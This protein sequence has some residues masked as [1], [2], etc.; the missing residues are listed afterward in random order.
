MCRQIADTAEYPVGSH[1]CSGR[2]SSLSAGLRERLS[3]DV[4]A[5]QLAQRARGRIRR[6]GRAVLA[7]PYPELAPDIGECNPAAVL[8]KVDDI[9]LSRSSLTL[10]YV[11][12]S[13]RSRPTTI[14]SPVVGCRRRRLELVEP[15]SSAARLLPPY[16]AYPRLAAN[17]ARL[18]RLNR[19]SSSSTSGSLEEQL[20]HQG[21]GCGQVSR[22]RMSVRATPGCASGASALDSRAAADHRAVPAHRARL[23]E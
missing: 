15:R 9:P 6:H 7:R 12:C 10:K 21:V 17:S 20:G 2:A 23:P 22:P 5:R 8:D 14:L 1:G 16:Q 4:N 11:Q 18:M 3:Q 19:S 13:S